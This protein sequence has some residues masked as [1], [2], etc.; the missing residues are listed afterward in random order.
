MTELEVLTMIAESLNA[1]V[2]LFAISGCAVVV[3]I[4]I[5]IIRWLLDD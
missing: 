1:I 2:A 5:G 3:Y 4:A